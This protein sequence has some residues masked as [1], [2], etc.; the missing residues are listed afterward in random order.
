MAT[1]GF[2]KKERLT[3]VKLWEAV[4]RE[5]GQIKAYPLLLY[6][7]KTPLP[8]AVPA[9]AGFA[10]PK[11]AFRKAVARN[12]IKRLMREAYRLE[13]PGVFNNSFGPYALVFLYLGKET[14]DFLQIS[15]A[16]KTLLKKIVPH[17]EAHEA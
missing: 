15:G 12:R 14:P 10:V 8:E 4:F 9:Q 5:G 1:F 3:R 11:R 7:L 2:P 13:K 6:Y 17:E 16:M